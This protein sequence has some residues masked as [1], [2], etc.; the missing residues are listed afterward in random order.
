L[1]ILGG[2][3]A[4]KLAEQTRQTGLVTWLAN[5]P[6]ALTLQGVTNLSKPILPSELVR[7]FVELAP[8]PRKVEVELE[9]PVQASE[10]FDLKSSTAG[11]RVLVAEDGEINRMVLV[12]LLELLGHSAT[13][14]ENGLQ[15]TQQAK[16]DAFDICLM[17][18]D[19]PEMDGIEATRVIRTSRNP[20]IIYAMTAHHDEHH[21]NLCREAGMNGYLTKPIQAEQLKQILLV[22]ASGKA[23]LPQ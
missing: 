17:D 22:V 2:P 12:G 15:A 8:A 20:L 7:H 16:K 14:V 3:E 1:A 21:A 10:L 19:M 23:S 5:P 18:L 9:V 6:D 11:L 4:S 13:V